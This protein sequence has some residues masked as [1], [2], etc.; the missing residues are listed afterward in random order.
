MFLAVFLYFGFLSMLYYFFE[1]IYLKFKKSK[2]CYMPHFC[3]ED[4]FIRLS[5]A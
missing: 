4:S 2:Y 3:F 1:I 5:L